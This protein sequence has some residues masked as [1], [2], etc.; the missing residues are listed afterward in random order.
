[1]RP[2]SM[3]P[4]RRLLLIVPAV[5]VA[6]LIA[7]VLVWD[8]N[9][10]RPLVERRA[11]AALGRQVTL[12]KFD[13]KPGWR[14]LLVADGVIV[15]NPPDFP[16]GPELGSIARLSVRLDL[17]R[18]LRR[19]IHL[20]EINAQ[21]PRGD[22][23]PGPAGVA[24]WKFDFSGGGGSGTPVEIGSLN[25]TDGYVTFFDPK[26]K[27]DVA[28]AVR[29]EAPDKGAGARLLIDGKGTYADQPITAR[30]I[31]GSVL[32]LRE[33]G[34]P[35]PVDL[36]VEN[37]STVISLKGTIARPLQ[38]GGADLD[39]HLRGNDLA[40]LYPLTGV[41]LPPSAAY[42]LKGKL[43]YSGERVRFIHFAGVVGK[44]DLGGDLE[45]DLT[46][47]KRLIT[48]ALHSDNVDLVDLAGF[49][50]AKP[51][52][53]AAEGPPV[54]VRPFRPRKTRGEY[55]RIRRSTCPASARPTWMCITKWRTSPTK[56]FRSTTW[57]PTSLSKTDCSAYRRLALASPKVGS[58]RI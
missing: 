3:T 37:G 17:R 39:L 20:L 9:W 7:L 45:I 36:Q 12:K 19:Q 34:H 53:P 49:T 40:A 25:I 21:R 26:Y 11:T 43:E 41:P 50:G 23:R 6:L 18:L 51:R 5:L 2:V 13:V 48:A 42:T 28:L 4:G 47:Q 33:P 14:P 10:F 56:S 52:K 44:S 30:F 55:C 58:L 29:T 16:A 15:A 31:G 8:W 32:S 54:R 46:R 22:L 27:T 35:Y 38:M 57:R 1:M 24:N